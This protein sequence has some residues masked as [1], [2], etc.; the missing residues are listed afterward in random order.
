MK[1]AKETF[2]GIAPFELTAAY[3]EIDSASPLNVRDDHIHNECEIYVNLSG[4]VAFAVEDSVYPVLPGSV[5][6]TRPLEYHRCIY[7]SDK[8]HRHF[9]ILFSSNGNERL[10]DIF[11]N[12]KAGERNMLIPSAE[13]VDELFSI[14]RSLT[15]GNNGELGKY[16]LFFRLIEILGGATAAGKV[17]ST[18]N[19]CL[20]KSIGLINSGLSQNITVSYLAGECNVSVNTL[21]RHFKHEL[22]I[23]PHEYIKKKRLLNAARLL[24]DG[25]SVTEAADLSGFSDCSKFISFFKKTYGITP[26]QYKKR[27]IS[28]K[29]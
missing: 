19:G 8:L 1:K 12:R 6:I 18:D 9:W 16:T 15:E 20:I 25:H 4:D 26:L 22:N 3:L 23:S 29:F 14:C 21:E 7:R 11:F 28:D 27:R 5:I 2:G 10:F 13:H 17:G 24:C